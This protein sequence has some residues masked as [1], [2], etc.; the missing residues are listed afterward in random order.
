MMRDAGQDLYQILKQ[1]FPKV[2]LTL[3]CQLAFRMALAV[4]H[5]HQHGVYHLDIKP[6]NVLV[7]ATAASKSN[8]SAMTL[9]DLEFSRTKKDITEQSL[10][11]DW[12][13][14]S[15]LY[16]PPE[17][18][19]LVQDVNNSKGMMVSRNSNN[20]GVEWAVREIDWERVDV[21]SLG[22]SLFSVMFYTSPFAS[23]RAVSSDE[24]YKWA[25]L[26]KWEEFWESHW[27]VKLIL[28]KMRDIDERRTSE[29]VELI[30]DMIQFK[31]KSRPRMKDVLAREMFAGFK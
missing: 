17:I 8:W 21:F 24:Q 30:S 27:Q 6:E 2:D 26:G 16:M 15:L 7:D 4:A 20:C 19:R 1:I 18:V 22:V 11:R 12:R 10:L 25:A 3:Y 28:K 14:R 31:S 29:L 23:G 13:S 9:I 5:L